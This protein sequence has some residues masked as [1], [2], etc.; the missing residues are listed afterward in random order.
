MHLLVLM[1]VFILILHSILP[2]C[3]LNFIDKMP[4]HPQRPSSEISKYL[5][6]GFVEWI[7][8][9]S[10]SFPF[11]SCLKIL[12]STEI[13]WRRVKKN[14]SS[15]DIIYTWNL[16]CGTMDLSTELKQTRRHRGQICGCHGG[17]GKGWDGLGVWV[18]R[19]KL[20]CLEW[21]SNDVLLYST[22]T[23]ISSLGIEHH[24][25]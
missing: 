4:F 25:R 3:I 1:L 21:I 19:Y 17:G 13:S 11:S 9:L 24:V 14:G 12:Q 16:K 6:K 15:Y 10:L 2:S 18:S 20:L 7:T 22:G 23:Y 5:L 8:V